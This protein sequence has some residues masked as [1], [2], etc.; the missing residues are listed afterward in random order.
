MTGKEFAHFY[1]I[2]I[3]SQVV[4]GTNFFVKIQELNTSMPRYS[5]P[6]LILMRKFK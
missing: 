1:P 3:R 2:G 6:S 5:D 4:A